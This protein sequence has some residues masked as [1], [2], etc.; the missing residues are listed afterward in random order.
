MWKDVFSHVKGQHTIFGQQ[1]EKVFLLQIVTGNKKWIYYNNPK[2]R[3]SWVKP[4]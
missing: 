4:G 3:K 2:S 1:T